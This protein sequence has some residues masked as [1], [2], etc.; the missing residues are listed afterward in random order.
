MRKLLTFKNEAGESLRVLWTDGECRT[1]PALEKVM[2]GGYSWEGIKTSG[3]TTP[4]PLLKFKRKIVEAD[5]R[6]DLLG[7]QNPPKAVKPVVDAEGKPKAKR[8]RNTAGPSP[9]LLKNM[10]ELAEAGKTLKDAEKEL[11]VSY[12]TLYVTAK[13]AGIVF[14]KGKKGRKKVDKPVTV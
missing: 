5:S 2:N 11:G 1:R 4:M 6:P 12:P 14:A 13:K 8:G 10:K 9:D 3:D 7:Y